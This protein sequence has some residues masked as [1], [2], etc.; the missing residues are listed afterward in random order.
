[1]KLRCISPYD[2]D[3]EEEDKEDAAAAAAADDDDNDCIMRSTLTMSVWRCGT[4]CEAKQHR[5]QQQQQHQ[6]PLINCPINQII[7]LG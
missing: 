3:A 5:Q 1:M 7:S 6:Q 2:D 4:E